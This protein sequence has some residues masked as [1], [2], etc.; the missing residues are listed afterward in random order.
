MACNTTAMD[1]VE[2]FC[3][4]VQSLRRIYCHESS[5]EDVRTDP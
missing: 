2:S 5:D 4:L 3:V 1:N